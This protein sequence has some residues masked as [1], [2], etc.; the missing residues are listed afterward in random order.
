MEQSKR[1]AREQQTKMPKKSIIVIVKLN[2]S[3]V[4]AI[5]KAVSKATNNN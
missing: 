1:E 4:K 3:T 2:K 5:N